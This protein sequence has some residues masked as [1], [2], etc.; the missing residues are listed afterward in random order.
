MFSFPQTTLSRKPGISGAIPFD[1]AGVDLGHHDKECSFEA[2]V[3]RYGLTSDPA[4]VL[5]GKIVNGVDID[6]T[7]GNLPEGSSLQAIAGGFR[8]LRLKDDHDINTPSG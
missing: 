5:L 6:N 7:L 3:K 1:V 8:H 4:L 2:I